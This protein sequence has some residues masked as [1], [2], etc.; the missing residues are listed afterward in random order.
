V[1]G[2]DTTLDQSV[3]ISISEDVIRV[4]GLFRSR[5]FALDAIV[6]WGV[7]TERA[8]VVFGLPPGHPPHVEPSTP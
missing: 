7:G 1:H 6:G 4:V 8:S 2:R 3:S 5:E